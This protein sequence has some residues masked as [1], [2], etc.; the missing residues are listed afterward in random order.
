M[1]GV[2]GIH[3]MIDAIEKQAPRRR[4][5]RR[6]LLHRRQPGRR[7]VQALS[8]PGFENIRTALSEGQLSPVTLRHDAAR[9]GG[10][11]HDAGLN[12]DLAPVADVVPLAPPTTMPESG[13][14]SASTGT[15][16]TWWRATSRPS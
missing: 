4:R 9:W 16:R 6:L 2:V 1:V 7:E 14:S 11:L 5:A 8:G 12:V 15:T 10:D 3:I 13:S